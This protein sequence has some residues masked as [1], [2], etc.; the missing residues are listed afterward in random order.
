MPSRSAVLRLLTGLAV[1][2]AILLLTLVAWWSTL[3]LRDAV[4]ERA[5]RE[6]QLEALSLSEQL[7]AVARSAISSLNAITQ[8]VQERGGPRQLPTAALRAELQREAGDEVGTQAMFVVDAD[9]KVVASVGLPESHEGRSLLDRPTIAYHFQHPTEVALHV[10]RAHYSELTGGWILPIS[11]IIASPEGKMLGVVSVAINLSH[12]RELYEQ[13]ENLREASLSI[14]G[15]NG[16]IIFR[17]PFVERAVGFKLP[18]GRSFSEGTGTYEAAS[19]IDGITRILSY[20]QLDDLDAVMLVGF[21]RDQVLAAWRDVA[22]ERMV[23][24]AS[25]LSLL[26]LLCGGAWLAWHRQRR[27]LRMITM[28]HATRERELREEAQTIERFSVALSQ[29]VSEPLSH[30]RGLLQTDVG[31][32]ATDA[33]TGARRDVLASTIRMEA[34]AKDLRALALARDKPIKREDLDLSSLAHAVARSQQAADPGRTVEFRIQAQ[35]YTTADAQLLKLVLTSLV[36]NAWKFT[37]DCP[38]PVITVG[39]HTG[40]NET[41]FCVRDNGPGFDPADARSLFKPFHRLSN[42]A[43]FEGHGIGLTTAKR[44]VERHG[45][46]IWAEG[47]KDHGAAFFFT[48]QP[49]LSISSSSYQAARRELQNLG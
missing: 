43:S 28:D 29:S 49:A 6:T 24:T 42:A 30:L 2:A 17:Y 38:H 23:W 7:S 15:R 20:R 37:R 36:G 12:M 32:A 25:S 22:R 8:S 45:G 33:P 31:G 13:M 26:A 18:G 47:G 3:P 19:P 16:E 14:I 5:H 11:R 10:G 39:A 27:Q 35:M 4:I 44:I 46:R 21:P 40:L 48:L 41:T 34:L 1:I 9:G